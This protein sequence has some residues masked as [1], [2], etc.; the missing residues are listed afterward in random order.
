MPLSDG[1]EVTYGTL[2]RRYCRTVL[3]RR[4]WTAANQK[5]DEQELYNRMDNLIISGL[6]LQNAAE[7]V[8]TATPENR[9]RNA[10]HSS[11]TEKSVLGLF[12]RHL[13]VPIWL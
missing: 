7:A 11:C 10:E 13:N 12:N 4:S 5:I 1:Q 8:T 2:Q 3:I 9:N 6:P